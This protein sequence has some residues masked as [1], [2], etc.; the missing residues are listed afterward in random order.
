M[1]NVNLH[2]IIYSINKK[3]FKYY[4]FVS[5]DSYKIYLNKINNMF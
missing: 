4:K 1:V 2:F 3:F 5:L